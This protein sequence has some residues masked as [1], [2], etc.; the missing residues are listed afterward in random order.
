MKEKKANRSE[1]RITNRVLIVFLS[2]G[3]M[4]WGL[5]YLFKYIDVGA[6]YRAGRRLALILGFAALA[7]AALSLAWYLVERKKR[8]EKERTLDGLLL[9]LIFAA[10]SACCFLL[11]YDNIMGMRMIYVFLP[12]FAALFLVYWVYEREFFTM[13]LVGSVVAVLL[14]ALAQLTTQYDMT[15]R[16]VA[17]ALGFCLCAA[18]ELLC[19]KAKKDKG[20]LRLGKKKTDLFGKTAD[21]RLQL[22]VYAVLAVLLVAAFIFGG[23]V[24]RYCMF[25]VIAA[26]ICGFVYFTIRLM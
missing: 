18:A 2:A 24:A 9:A 1:E 20:M 11:W 17:L 4:L 7:C 26:M 16:I 19:L 22:I 15:R 5:S 14:N 3:V 6:T 23:S 21:K 8:R 10:L 25:A 13:A 12:L